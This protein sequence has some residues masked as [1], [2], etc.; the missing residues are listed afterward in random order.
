MGDGF[1]RRVDGGCVRRTAGLRPAW[2]VESKKQVYRETHPRLARKAKAG[3]SP[4]VRQQPGDA[5]H[6]ITPTVENM[7]WF[8]RSLSIS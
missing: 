6:Q 2:D 5:P 8:I 7:Q 4:A 3:R 1:R